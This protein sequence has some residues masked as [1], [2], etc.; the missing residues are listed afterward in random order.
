MYVKMKTAYRSKCLSCHT[1]FSWHASKRKGINGTLTHQWSGHPKTASSE[2][3]VNIICVL[4][5][6]CSLTCYYIATQSH[7]L[8]TPSSILLDS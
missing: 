2:T 8:L 7:K 1:I 6:Y 3:N 5:K 4:I